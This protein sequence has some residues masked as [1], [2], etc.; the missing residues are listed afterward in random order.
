[1]HICDRRQVVEFLR[2][3]VSV[4]G[5]LT[6]AQMKAFDAEKRRKLRESLGTN[7]VNRWVNKKLRQWYRD[8]QLYLIGQNLVPGDRPLWFDGDGR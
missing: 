2:G 6:E 5:A 8:L 1:M 4:E 3:S 7:R